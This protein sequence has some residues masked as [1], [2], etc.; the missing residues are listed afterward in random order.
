MNNLKS[1]ILIILVQLEKHDDNN[2]LVTPQH[3]IRLLKSSH[4]QYY[5]RKENGTERIYFYNYCVTIR[6][7]L[8]EDRCEY[9]TVT[10]TSYSDDKEITLYDAD[11]YNPTY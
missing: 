9:Q 1:V 4:V 6:P 11:I 5:C 10:V 8:D 2:M 3:I 7:R